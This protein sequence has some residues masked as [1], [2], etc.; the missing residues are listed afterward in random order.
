MGVL[1]RFL[2]GGFEVVA[3]ND[4]DGGFLAA[5]VEVGGEHRLEVRARAGEEFAGDLHVRGRPAVGG[6]GL[7][8]GVEEGGEAAGV[9]AGRGGMADGE[10]LALLPAVGG[11]AAA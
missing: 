11:G 8:D 5:A 1:L 4:S 3:V 2:Q 7:G 6:V 10:G 9:V